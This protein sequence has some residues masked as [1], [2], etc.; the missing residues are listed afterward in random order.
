MLE[1]LDA[2]TVAVL[3]LLLLDLLNGSATAENIINHKKLQTSSSQTKTKI[4]E[5]AQTS[6]TATL[7]ILYADYINIVKMFI[8]SK[9]TG[10]WNMHLLGR[11]KMFN[12][13]AVTRHMHYAKRACLY[14]QLMKILQEISSW[15]HKK[16]ENKAIPR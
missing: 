7:R 1:P 4:K 16:F 8:T 10:S 12:L 14:L 11:E 5:I 6:Q 15:L 9:Q 13:L 2:E 3:E